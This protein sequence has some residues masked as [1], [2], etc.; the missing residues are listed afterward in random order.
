MTPGPDP[1]GRA[2]GELAERAFDLLVIGGG[3]TGSGIAREAARAGLAVALVDRSDFGSETSSTSSKLVH[4]GLRYLRRGHVGL[5]REA[6]RERRALAQVVAPHL[7]RPLPFFLPVYGDGP[8]R[9]LTIRAA[10]LFYSALAREPNAGLVSR[11]EAA[12]RVPGLRLDGLRACGT[13]S[14]AATHDGR[15]CLANVRG[16]DEAGAT[17]ANYAET[18]ALRLEGGRVAGA[19]IADRLTGAGV[20][21]RARTVVNATGPWVDR[22]RRL[23]DPGAAPSSRLSKGV[24]V[25][26]PLP[27]GWS[28]ALVVPHGGM[29][30]TFALPWQGMLLAGT[31]DALYEGEPDQVA[32]SDAEVSQ[33]LSEAAVAVAPELV[34][35]EAVRVRFAG[36]RVLPGRG[37][38]TLGATRE[39]VLVRGPAGMVSVAGGKLTT[40]RRTA[41]DVLASL[42]ADLGLHRVDRRPAALPGATDPGAV[43]A[44]L[45]RRFPDLE[46]DARSH[47]AHLYGALAEE[48]LEPAAEDAE[49]LRP[50]HPEAPDV[51]AQAAYA[52]AHEWATS[53]ADVLWR[54][55]TLGWRGL[56]S[57][58]LSARL[59]PPAPVGEPDATSA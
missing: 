18:T 19:E 49:L 30:V 45:G 11:N 28:A 24:H 23:E 35:P 41:L 46:P 57:P 6:H 42:R 5:V 43:S 32:A 15:L 50:L 33:V 10:L 25:L 26:L 13:Y 20:A 48:V 56:A 9:P 27:E 29:R 12:R 51:A 37:G 59:G 21:V 39:T 3:I 54:R 58:E 17:V 16:A 22:V 36:L 40:Y 55:T 44:G 4:G 31:T 7:V 52:Y 8:Y 1:R 47:L 34:R 38:D 53:P 2:L 14:D